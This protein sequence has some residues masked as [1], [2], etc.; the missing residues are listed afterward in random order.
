MTQTLSTRFELSSLCV[1]GLNLENA[2]V[3]DTD[4]FFQKPTRPR[5]RC[6]RF[7]TLKLLY[8]P[9][10]WKICKSRRAYFTWKTTRCH[11]IICWCD[12]KGLEL[13]RCPSIYG[14]SWDSILIGPSTPQ[15]AVVTPVREKTV[16]D[17]PAAATSS[18]NRAS[19]SK[20]LLR[21]GR[22]RLPKQITHL[23]GV[24]PWTK[25]GVR[26]CV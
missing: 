8:P 9:K 5:H 4:G 13:A 24:M 22:R 3:T 16:D 26:D 17:R 11:F 21:G 18:D 1:S 10:N 23:A 15:G 12:N 25:G 20:S 7:W 6:C 2:W 19:S 14:R